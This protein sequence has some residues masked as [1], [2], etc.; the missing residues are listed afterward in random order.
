[1][2]EVFVK[3]MIL[4]VTLGLIHGLFIVPAFLCAFTSI[5]HACFSSSKVAHS[6][7]RHVVDWSDVVRIHISE[8]C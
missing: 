7:V 4:V 3:T 8:K 5:H 1:M 6:Q 2:G